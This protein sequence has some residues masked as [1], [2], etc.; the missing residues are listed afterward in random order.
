[1]AIFGEKKKKLGYSFLQNKSSQ[2]SLP[3]KQVKDE[4]KFES[5]RAYIKKP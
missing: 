1:M 2:L 5:S 3:I 4:S